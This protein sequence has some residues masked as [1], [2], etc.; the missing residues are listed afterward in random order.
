MIQNVL[1]EL[2][3]IGIYGVISVCLFFSVFGT[4]LVWAFLLKKPFLNTMG[5][6]PLEDER[7]A[8]V[9]KG[10]TGHE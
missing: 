9:R 8:K 2:G 7:P 5:S 1:R 4:A 3:G 6:L 10:E